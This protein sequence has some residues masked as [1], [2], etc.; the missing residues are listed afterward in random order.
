MGTNAASR[1]SG[2]HAPRLSLVASSLPGADFDLQ[3]LDAIGLQVVWV[4][5]SLEA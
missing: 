2:S 4:R 1:P 5:R 3:Q